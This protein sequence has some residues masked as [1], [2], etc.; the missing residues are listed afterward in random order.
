MGIN[1]STV[2]RWAAKGR[3]GT[4]PEAQAFAER[5]DAIRASDGER[6]SEDDVIRALEGAIRKGSV[7][8]MRTWLDRYGGERK[9]PQVQPDEFDDLKARRAARGG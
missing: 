4:S 5:F 6:L 8:A 1:P 9:P 3:A 2:A 7:T